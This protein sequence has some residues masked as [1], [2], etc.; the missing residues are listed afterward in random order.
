MVKIAVVDIETSGFLAQGGTIVEVGIAGLDLDTG[1]V[2]E[3]FDMI[4]KEEAFNEDHTK[5]PFGWIFQNSDLRYQDVLDGAPFAD[6]KAQIQAVFDKFP[7]GATAFNKQFDF[8][9][10]RDRGLKIKD[11]SC[12][13]LKATPIV[14]LPPVGNRKSPKWPKVEEAWEYFFPDIP[15]VEKHRALDDAMHEAKI[16]HAIIKLEKDGKM[17]NEGVKK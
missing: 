4:V 10:L 13:M 5:N 8:G 14:G 3:E 1:E 16:A 6:A 12:I 9:F 11:L 15:Y 17:L 2:T 7:A